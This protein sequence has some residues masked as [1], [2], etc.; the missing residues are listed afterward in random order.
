MASANVVELWRRLVE[1][2]GEEAIERA[3]TVS[4]GEAERELVGAGFDVGLE[5]RVASAKIA[6]LEG[7]AR[8]S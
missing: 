8:R 4:V 2:A 6:A 1:E 7:P 3:A 5:R